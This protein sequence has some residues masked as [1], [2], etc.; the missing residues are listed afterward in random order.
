MD[1]HKI[2]IL[3]LSAVG[4]VIRTLPAI[5]ALKEHTP[6]SI[7][8]IV[9]EPSQDLL[10]SQPEVDEVI[11]FPRKRWTQGMKS[12]RR[13]WG[14]IGEMWEF[15]MGLRKRRF[16]VVLDFHGILKS[17]LLSFFQVPQEDWI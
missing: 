12:L 15:I 2:L 6:S 1:S 10:E 16:D 11:L 3:R 8:W 14:T 7:T 4:D 5:K 13:M 9:E 17:G